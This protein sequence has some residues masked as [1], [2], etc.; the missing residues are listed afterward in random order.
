M[1]RAA[2]AAVD[3]VADNFRLVTLT[4]PALAA[5]TW[6]PGQKVQIGMGTGLATRTYTPLD[7][8]A[9]AG[10]TR[11]LGYMHG[12]G[13]GTEWLRAI[14]VGVPCDV[15]GPRRSLDVRHLPGPLSI[16]GDETSIALASAL[17]R[18]GGDRPVTSWL[19]VSDPASAEQVSAAL[20]LR[21]VTWF[22][23]RQGDAHGA[24]MEEAARVRAA[25]GG[26]FVLTGKAGTVQRLRHALKRAG[27][28]ADRIAT[29][30]YWAPG[31]T[32][33]D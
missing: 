29:K 1:K 10:R 32:G 16:F 24:Q 12:A 7:W 11:L 8:D 14:R 2:V 19:E 25:G 31:K 27:V 21:D 20:G 17:A 26:S 28:S 23:K 30:A 9:A 6:E 22:A 18:H 33:M 13:P 3:D 5:V 15:F 4:G